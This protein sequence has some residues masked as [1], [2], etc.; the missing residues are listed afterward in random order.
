MRREAWRHWELPL[1]ESVEPVD[2]GATPESSSQATDLQRALAAAISTDLTPHQRRVT[3]ALLV[4][5]VPID[6]LA[7]RLGTNRNALY[8]TL[9][10]ARSRLRASLLASGHL[11][12]TTRRSTS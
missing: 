5:V 8:K 9:H 2:A 1:F 7:E 3:L 6:V 10:D 11:V 4:D 12:E